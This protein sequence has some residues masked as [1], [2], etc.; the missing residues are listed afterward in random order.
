MPAL[1]ISLEFVR[2][3]LQLLEVLSVAAKKLRN[4]SRRWPQMAAAKQ[5]SC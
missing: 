4:L 5:R 1:L 3:L 2:H